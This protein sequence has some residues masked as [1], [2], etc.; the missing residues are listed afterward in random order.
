M[1]QDIS[2]NDIQKQFDYKVWYV[3]EVESSQCFSTNLQITFLTQFLNF[4]KFLLLQ[5][6]F[7]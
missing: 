7:E 1:I 3:L 2:F 5:V 6:N 4:L